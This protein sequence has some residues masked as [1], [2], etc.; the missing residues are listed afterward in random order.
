MASNVTFDEIA[1]GQ[2]ARY[3]RTVETRHIQLFAAATGDVNPVH[4]DPAFAAATAFGEP[5]A[6]GMLTGGLVSA[7]LALVLPGPGTIF[8]GQSLRFRAPVKVGDTVT[9]ELT[10]TEKRERRQWVALDC[11]VTNQDGKVVA[12]GSAEVM[13]PTEK[14][15][16]ALPP[17]PRVEILA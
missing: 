6:H 12:S 16:V 1:V 11:R 8:L 5:I 3:S 14:L 2:S 7:A 4:L 9:V 15:S 17:E 13:A 10:V